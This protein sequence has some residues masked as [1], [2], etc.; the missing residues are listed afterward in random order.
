[1]K[2]VVIFLPIL[3][4][5][6]IILGLLV[7]PLGEETKYKH[8]L[9]GSGTVL[10]FLVWMPIFLFWRMTKTKLFD[11]IQKKNKEVE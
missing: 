1:M 7:E 2:Y 9:L 6:L 8:Y 4:L 11:Q 3:A 10:I 5:I